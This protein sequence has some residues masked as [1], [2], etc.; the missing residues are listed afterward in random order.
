MREF[1]ILLAVAACAAALSLLPAQAWAQAGFLGLDLG[2]GTSAPADDPVSVEAVFTAEP[3]GRT[4]TLYITA[5]MADGWHI[6]SITQ[7]PGGPIRTNL[8]LDK[9][10]RFRLAGDFKPD[11]A[12][13]KHVDDQA[14]PGLTLEEHEGAVTWAAPLK[15][16][17][18][19]DPQTLKIAGKVYV[20]SCNAEN[21]NPPKNY[22]FSAAYAQEKPAA[23]GQLAPAARDAADEAPAG[24]FQGQDVKFHGSVSPKV[25]T[26]GG[27][28]RLS[29]TAEPAEGWHIY[30]LSEKPATSGSKPTLLVLTKTSG[31][32][33]GPAV[34]SDRPTVE[35]AN[36]LGYHDG[37]V[38]WTVELK[39]PRDAKTD[40]IE[41]EGLLAYQVCNAKLCNQPAALA[42][43]GK[44]A[45]GPNGV[46]GATPLE[47]TGKR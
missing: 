28:V 13:R 39:V 7:A 5:T 35:P 23:S 18:D 26:P 34:A 33:S 25:A 36:Q 43:S 10:D 11:P 8:K 31:L 9:S 29:I 41:I 45:I 42:F 46:S 30:A 3:D 47:I 6:Y 17:A 19:V 4:G 16:A 32:V 44:L 21:C 12:P 22:S 40:L 14:F 37:K 27:R 1:R 24:E 2:G 20:Q 15:F 38:T